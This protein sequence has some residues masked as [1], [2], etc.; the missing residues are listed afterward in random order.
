MG[1]W[2][3]VVELADSDVAKALSVLGGVVDVAAIAKGA[4]II[5]SKWTRG[6]QSVSVECGRCGSEDSEEI[7]ELDGVYCCDLCMDD[8]DI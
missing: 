6:P 3:T 5:V 7:W 2:E 8:V 1:V 4:T